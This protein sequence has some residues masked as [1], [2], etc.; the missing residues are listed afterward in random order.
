[1]ETRV[2]VSHAGLLGLRKRA[3]RHPDNARIHDTRHQPA[4]KAATRC[5][6]FDAAR[7]AIDTLK[8]TLPVWKEE[9][10]AGGTDWGTSSCSARS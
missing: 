10:W 4:R 5:A 6:T 9:A 2:G 3:G 1:M 7:H 8:V